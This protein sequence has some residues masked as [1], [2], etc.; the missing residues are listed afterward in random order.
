MTYRI[1][2]HPLVARDLDAIAQ[3]ILDYAGPDIAARQLAERKHRRQQGRFLVEGV[4]LLDLALRAG[5]GSSSSMRRALEE[6]YGLSPRELRN[7][8]A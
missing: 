8:R 7:R 2:F 6:I 4:K 3:W 5:F 1:R